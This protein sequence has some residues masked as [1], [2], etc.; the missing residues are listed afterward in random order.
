[1]PQRGTFASEAQGTRGLT[2]QPEAASAAFALYSDLLSGV[3]FGGFP[4]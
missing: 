4:R 2:D 3:G 1:M